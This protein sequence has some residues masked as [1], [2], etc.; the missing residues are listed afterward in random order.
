MS[1]HERMACQKER[2]TGA[3]PEYKAEIMII[4][5]QF[6]FHLKE[7]LI[8]A[9]KCHL[10]SVITTYGKNLPKSPILVVSYLRIS[11]RQRVTRPQEKTRERETEIEQE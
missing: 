8:S 11:V 2:E 10:G 1:F 7:S 9:R 4:K 6:Q 3:S 5:S